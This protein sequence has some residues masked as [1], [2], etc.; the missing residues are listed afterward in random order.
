M[1][2]GLNPPLDSCPAGYAMIQNPAGGWWSCILPSMFDE[3]YA[4]AGT[5]RIQ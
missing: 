4:P 2:S 5:D 3:G 1:R